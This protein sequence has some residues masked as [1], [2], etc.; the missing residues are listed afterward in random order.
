MR[1]VPIKR[2]ILGII[3]L[4]IALE[5]GTYYLYFKPQEEKK[6][7]S[8]FYSDTPTKDYRSALTKKQPKTATI[9]FQNISYLRNTDTA[10]LVSSQAINVYKGVVISIEKNLKSDKNYVAILT[11]KDSNEHKFSYAYF[12]NDIKNMTITNKKTNLELASLFDLKPEMNI[13]ITET[14]DMLKTF[15]SNRQ[16]VKIAVL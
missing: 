8:L 10:F 11:L 3:L 13:E 2:L 16:Q 9:P 4:F 12:P 5:L 7:Q 6:I 14:L 15:G 1:N